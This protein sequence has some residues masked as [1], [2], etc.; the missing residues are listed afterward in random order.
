[1]QVKEKY[2]EE[3]KVYEIKAIGVFNHFFDYSSITIHD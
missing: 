3:N 1:M 2:S